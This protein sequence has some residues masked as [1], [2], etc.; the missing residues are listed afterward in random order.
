MVQASAT[1]KNV[2]ITILARAF[3]KNKSVNY[4]IPQDGKR[5]Q[6][7]RHLMAYSFDVCNRFGQVFL[8]D[9]RTACALV[10]FPDKKKTTVQSVWWDVRLLASCTGI[11]NAGKVLS[12]EAKIKKR[13]PAGALYYLWFIG[14]DPLQQNKGTG[15]KLLQE[16]I[17]ESE[18][19]NRVL[20]LETSTVENIPWYR[21]FGFEIYNELHLPY[22]L[23]FL[24]KA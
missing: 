14:T 22:R 20:C 15:S 12:R 16:V 18:R 24:K 7:I 4:V 13:Q 1:D 9:D 19:A 11:F 23:F 5:L 10:L 21:K 3:D 6:R 8:S 2:V 17:R